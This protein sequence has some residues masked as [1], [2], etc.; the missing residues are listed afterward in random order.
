MPEL[1]IFVSSKDSSSEGNFA[2]KFEPAL[3]IPADAKSATISC[4]QMTC[5]YT[6][7]NVTS[8]NNGFVVSVPNDDNTAFLAAHDGS[9][10]KNKRANFMADKHLTQITHARKFLKKCL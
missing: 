10:M 2:I 9:A 4:Q 7:P 8:E 6:M 1:P 5:P 3:V